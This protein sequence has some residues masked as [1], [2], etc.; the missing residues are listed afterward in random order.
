MRFLRKQQKTKEMN[1]YTPKL[2]EAILRIE[3][4]ISESQKRMSSILLISYCSPTPT[5]ST[6]NLRDLNKELINNKQ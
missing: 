4:A 6:F 5:E 1:I 3:K 2:N